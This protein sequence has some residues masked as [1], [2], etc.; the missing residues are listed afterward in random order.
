[1]R[2][3]NPD[4][5]RLFLKGPKTWTETKKIVERPACLCAELALDIGD[6]IT[7]EKKYPKPSEC[8]DVFCKL[9]ELG[10]LPRKFS[11]E[12]VHIAKLRNF[13][14]HDYRKSTLPEFGEISET[15]ARGHA[16]RVDDYR[17]GY[18]PSLL[19]VWRLEGCFYR[20]RF[21]NL[22]VML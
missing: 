9:G 2:G 17:E 1:V 11:Q 12:F 3:N 7:V 8:S 4:R 20:R 14:A 5:K 21:A 19:A 10:V 18:A 13:L 16:S 22:A 6:L 15:R